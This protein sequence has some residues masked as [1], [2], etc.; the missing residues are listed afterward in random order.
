MQTRDISRASATV[1]PNELPAIFE[2][3]QQNCAEAAERKRRRDTRSDTGSST[4]SDR[5][6]EARGRRQNGQQRKRE[7]KRGQVWQHGQYKRRN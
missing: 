7:R 6:G 2:L 1:S 4:S 5:L 3:R